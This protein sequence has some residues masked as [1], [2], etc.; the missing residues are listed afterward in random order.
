[1]KEMHAAGLEQLKWV[2]LGTPHPL[3]VTARLK[4]V[5]QASIFIR[6]LKCGTRGTI[7][8]RT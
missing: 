8:L 5:E 6:V 1:M 3:C 2:Y 4:I 7:A